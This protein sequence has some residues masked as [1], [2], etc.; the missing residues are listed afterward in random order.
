MTHIL[1][2]DVNV[3]TA[4]RIKQLLDHYSISIDQATTVQEALNRVF[5]SEPPYDIVILDV[6]LGGDD[7]YALM[8]RL[9]RTYPNLLLVV[10][11]SLNTRSSFVEAIKRGASDYV[12]KPYDNDYLQGKLKNHLTAIKTSKSIENGSP[13]ELENSIYIQ[14]KK[15]VREKTELLIGLLVIYHNGQ[16]D[17][18]FSNE[19]DAVIQ[20]NLI[21]KF[22]EHQ[23]EGDE[24]FERGSNAIVFIMPKRAYAVKEKVEF[25]VQQQ[26]EYYLEKEKIEHTFVA[27]AFVSLPKEVNENVN[28]LS[29]LAEQ[30]EQK[31]LEKK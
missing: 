3:S 7:G 25:S 11:T 12:L 15:A 1:V 9:H 30:V 18:H 6:H 22:K 27:S 2:V 20:R 19:S 26:S 5:A 4:F 10:L 14:V 13:K 29:V 17:T 23:N 31:I 16:D 8:D 24:I 28:A 21:K